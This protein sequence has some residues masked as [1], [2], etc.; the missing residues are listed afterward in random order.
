M[1]KLNL[2]QLKTLKT[3]IRNLNFPMNF[4]AKLLLFLAQNFVHI[5]MRNVQ[6]I[7]DILVTAHLTPFED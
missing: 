4:G 6:N 2:K 5:Y 7:I 1:N 3:I